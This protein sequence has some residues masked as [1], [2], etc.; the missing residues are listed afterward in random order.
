[1]SNRKKL[2]APPQEQET[3]QPLHVKYRPQ[4]FE[5]VK[6]QDPVIRSLAAA[7]AAKARPHVFLFTGGPGT[8]KTTLARIVTK[9]LGVASNNVVEVDAGASGGV[10][11]MRDVME[12]LRYHGFGDNP[13]KSVILDEAHMLTKQ[14]WTSL[15]KTIEEPP[16]HVFFFFCT[17]EAS[18]V[19]TNIQTR[20]LAY[21]LRQVPREDILDLLDEVCEE[22][23][24]RTPGKILQQI[25]AACEGS[26][27]QAL[28]ML[29]K[30]QEVDDPEEA[31]RLLETPSDN[32]EVIDLCRM[33]I[34]GDLRWDRMV[35]TIKELPEMS[36]ES[37][38]IIVISYLNACLM[39]AKTEREAGR[40]LNL[41]YPFSRSFNPTDKMAP[42]MMA[43][44]DLILD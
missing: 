12:P 25:A 31:A 36:P 1:M 33:L 27:R 5:D 28:V 18:K 10:D 38:R 7:L 40:I 17:T 3:T 41:M 34:K 30:L 29:A 23:G 43:F 4:R 35:S 21:H 32:K 19:P 26:P 13:Y 2:G 8:G 16:E 24:I 20:C 15:L 42:L 37:I 6:G 14:A 44:G 11:V 9:Q 22:E 39:G